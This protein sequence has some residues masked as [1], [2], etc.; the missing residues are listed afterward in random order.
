MTKP[1]AIR[2]QSKI[3]SLANGVVFTSNS[4]RFVDANQNFRT[5]T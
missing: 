2:V 4:F 5:S 1:I 3:S